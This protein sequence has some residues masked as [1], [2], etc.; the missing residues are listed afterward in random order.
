MLPSEI[1]AQVRRIEIRTGRL[2]AETLAGEYLSVFKGQGIEFAE[3]REYQPGDD[4]RTIDWNVTAR[5][6]R[7]FVK[8]FAEERELTVLI[9]CDLSG[10]LAFGSQSKLKREIATELS[11]L[12]AFSAMSNNDKAGL[13]LFTDRV[14]KFIPPRKGRLHVLRLLRELLAFQP[15]QRGTAIASSLEA[16][17][18]MVRRR[19]ILFLISDFMDT[20]YEK[21]LRRLA[22]RHDLVP[23]VLEDPRESELPDAPVLIE[24]EDAETG[25][26]ALVPAWSKSVRESYRKTAAKRRQ[27]LERFFKS[28]GIEHIRVRTD[29]S[30]VDPVVA[31]FKNRS[32]RHR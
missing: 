6:G 23:I 8:R 10:S 3:V 22:K 27:E 1:L 17:Q 12:L 13:A 2:V 5:L 32:R 29:K 26:R 28:A 18:R 11:A 20:G 19:G 9:A 24:V 14:E 25:E 30:Y 21:V 31:F 15:E 4:I 7:P 16:V